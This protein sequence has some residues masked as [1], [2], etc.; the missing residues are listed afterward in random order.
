MSRGTWRKWNAAACWVAVGLAMGVLGCFVVAEL[1]G[2]RDPYF[3]GLPEAI[4]VGDGLT[5]GAVSD[6]PPVSIS[7][8][9][10]GDDVP[11][12][13]DTGADTPGSINTGDFD[14]SGYPIGPV[15][16]VTATDAAG[17]TRT[18]NVRDE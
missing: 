9:V 12:S 16:V 2:T 17:Q 11:G 5:V 10:D 18:Q 15:L 13:P 1:G 14:T 7:V 4:D 6:N 8:Q 3:I